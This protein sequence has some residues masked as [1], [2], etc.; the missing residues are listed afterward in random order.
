MGVKKKRE[1]QVAAVTV[2]HQDLETLRYDLLQT[3]QSTSGLAVI[4]FV[5]TMFHPPEKLPGLVRID[6]LGLLCESNRSTEVVSIEEMQWVRFFITYNLNSQSPGVRQQICSLLKK[7]AEKL[8][9]LFQA[10]LELST[11]TKPYDCVTASY[12][13]NLLIWQDALPASLTASQ[14]QQLTH[15]AHGAAEKA[16]VLERNTLVV[17]KCLMENLE[18]EISQAED[19]LLQAASSFPMYGR[20]H[21]ITRAFQK[22]PLND[23]R[24]VSEW[25]PV[26]EGLLL[27]SYRLSA[28]V[29]PV[30]QSSS[31]EGLI[32]MDTDS[33]SASRLQVILNEI[34]PR[35]TNAY[36][37]QA[38]ILKEC[39]SFDLEDLSASV[40]NIDSSAEIK[41]KE[42][43]TCDVTAQMVLVCCWRSM[44]EVAL[45]LGTLCQLLP[46][47]PVPESSNGLLT[48]QQVK[49]IGDYFKQ[50]LLQSRHRGAFELAYTGFVKLTEILNRCSAVSL[51]KLPEQWLWNVLEEIKSSDPSSKLCATRRS[52]GIPFYI[53]VHALNIL[54]ALFRDTRLGENIIP[55]VADGAKA[56][57]LGFTSPVWAVS[58]LAI[59]LH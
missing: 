7:D 26:V 24:L 18:D 51:Q 4:L 43:K 28:V 52:A 40:S 1:V 2:C 35:D 9:G 53:Q 57:I 27:L 33:E 32:P 21:C 41:G 6:T 13:L 23:L 10:A 3:I 17:I 42:T 44:K 30:I 22:L 20:V 19:S 31:P 39:D 14:A 11:S 29:S 48:V 45:L 47:R 5:K 16:T 38:K 54:R 56:A 15:R 37:N 34:Q 50:H 55:Y 12:L 46:M 49:E 25:R 58:V 36:F 8:Q 59:C